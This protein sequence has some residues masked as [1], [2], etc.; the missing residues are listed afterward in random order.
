MN[1]SNKFLR[2]KTMVLATLTVVFFYS[3]CEQQ[4]LD[5]G[6]SVDIVAYSNPEME[7]ELNG[8]FKEYTLIELNTE[9]LFEQMV[10]AEGE[11]KNLTLE[12]AE[13]PIN[14]FELINDNAVLG[15]VPLEADDEFYYMTSTGDLNPNDISWFSFNKDMPMYASIILREDDARTGRKN[16][17][18]IIES[19]ESYL[20]LTDEEANEGKYNNLYVVY[21]FEDYIDPNPSATCGNEESDNSIIDSDDED[22]STA[23]TLDTRYY[24]PWVGNIRLHY[25]IGWHY[26]HSFSGSNKQDRARA[27]TRDRFFGM[28]HLYKIE[29]EV[30]IEFHRSVYWG[31]FT[32]ND[33]NDSAVEILNEVKHQFQNNPVANV[34]IVSLLHNV[35]SSGHAG[36][37]WTPGVC[38]YNYKYN[39]VKKDSNRRNEMRAWGHEIGHNLGLPHHPNP[40]HMMHNFSMGSSWISG[41]ERNIMNSTH[42]YYC[43]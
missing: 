38:L 11:I 16:T 8:L 14:D 15:D 10:S 36:R 29:Q 17:V 12:I 1:F 26:V 39:V 19:V 37:A 41:A 31:W 34:K 21:N 7:S 4:P 23:N 18:H 6:T 22:N 32:W 40:S 33:R 30:G 2:L 43:N 13:I 3:S 27:Q 42:D 9:K 28:R 35:A 5:L 25:Y 20:E 24:G